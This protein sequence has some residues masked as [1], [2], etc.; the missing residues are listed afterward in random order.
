MQEKRSNRKEKKAGMK[1]GDC[2]ST[3]GKNP[4]KLK[5]SIIVATPS[6]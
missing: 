6:A 1:E 3:G 4:D 5:K 2:K